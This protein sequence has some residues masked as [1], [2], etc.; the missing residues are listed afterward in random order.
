[1]L[2]VVLP[3]QTEQLVLTLPLLVGQQLQLLVVDMG[4]LEILVMAVAVVQAAVPREDL[5]VL[6]VLEHLVKEIQV[7]HLLG[8]L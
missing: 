6:E 8:L 5:R 3:L 7:D 2:V 4:R 1:V